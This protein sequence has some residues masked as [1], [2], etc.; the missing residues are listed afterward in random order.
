MMEMDVDELI[1]KL[2]G[3]MPLS[4]EGEESSQHELYQLPVRHSQSGAEIDEENKPTIVS[5]H[6]PGKEH[7]TPTHPDGHTGI[8]LK[9]PEG[10]PVY[11]IASGVVA[12]TGT[13][14]KSGNWVLTLHEEGKVKAFY[15]HL[16]RILATKGDEVTS[17]TV[18]GEV[19]ETGNAAG[20][21]AHLHYQ[22]S[23]DGAKFD[24]QALTGKRVGSLSKKAEVVK[25][26][27][28]MLDSKYNPSRK[29]RIDILRKMPFDD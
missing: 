3:S 7:A 24:P 8:D 20:R 18:I 16:L 15:G 23:I 19:G 6:L 22:V 11:A 25:K 28:A 5:T 26:I 4:E 12:A 10:S 13:N 9:A 17:D 14:P 21:G 2:V 27:I 29:E 1:T